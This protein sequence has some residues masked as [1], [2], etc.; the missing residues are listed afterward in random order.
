MSKGKEEFVDGTLNQMFEQRNAH[1]I[2]LS[3]MLDTSQYKERCP[4]PDSCN[5][6]DLRELLYTFGLNTNLPIQEQNLTHRN[7]K[8]DIVSCPRWVG[9]KRRDPEWLSFIN[10]Y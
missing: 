7:L 4:T 1:E 10:S 9:V 3:D 6:E 5:Y 8:G 2:S